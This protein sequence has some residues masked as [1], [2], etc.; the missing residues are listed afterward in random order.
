MTAGELVETLRTR[1]VELE[2]VG[3][4]LRFRPGEAVTPKERE[5]LRRQKAEVLRL[6][7]P[8]VLDTVT[9]RAVLGHHPKP[10]PVAALE[11]EL[12]QAISQYRVEIWTG[13]LGAGVLLVRGRPL[14]DWLDLDTVARLLGAAKR[15][16]G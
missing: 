5:A 4:R 6:L 12:R 10:E 3:D 11:A 15:R 2:A 14:A 1:G 13:I 16:P 8:L 7:E 9:L